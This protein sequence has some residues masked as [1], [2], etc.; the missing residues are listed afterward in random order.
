MKKCIALI[1]EHASPLGL[2]GGVDSGGQNVYVGQVA[3]NLA[4]LGHEVDVFTRRDSV[5]LPEVSAWVDGVRIIHVPAGP[6]SFVRKEDMLPYIGKFTDYMKRFCRDQ[7]RSYDLAHANF[8]MS[9]QVACDLKRDLGLPFVVTFHALGRVRRQF[10]KQDDQFPDSRFGV[11]DRIVDEA[12]Y[13]IAECPQDEEDLIRFY[14]ADPA[15]IAVVPCGF[16]P[17]ELWP[18]S[19]PLAR[20]T[21]GLDPNVPILLH[22]GRFVPRKGIDTTIRGFAHL[23]KIHGIAARLVIVGGES[24]VPDPELTPEMGRL[25]QIA[26]AEGVET[27]ILFTGRRGREILRYY[28]SAAD[29]FITMPW[30]EPFGITPVEAMAC[31]TPVVGANVGGV[32][33]TV[34]DGETGYLVPP[35]DHVA[36]SDKLA[37]LYQHPERLS[38]FS[39][40][41]VKRANELF[42]WRKVARSLASL[43]EEVPAPHRVGRPELALAD[44]SIDRIPTKF[45]TMHQ[46]AAGAATRDGVPL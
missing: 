22:L 41:A 20:C 30:Y 26:R 43:Y 2:L 33:F 44:L 9:G 16:D 14:G 4:A 45:P 18:I 38:M 10:Q 25:M 13:I 34:R 12:D 8:W 40:Q 1:S 11:E 15:R 31:A 7:R 6:A 29:I 35:Q 5:H 32:K 19:K 17:D 37:H 39:R 36:L 46:R 27:D 42:T 24:E 3:K 21:L 23:R 28:Y